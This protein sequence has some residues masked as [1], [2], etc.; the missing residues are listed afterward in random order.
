MAGGRPHR[1]ASTDTKQDKHRKNADILIPNGIR[2]H[3]PNIRA[4]EGIMRVSLSGH[5]DLIYYY[6]NYH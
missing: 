4:V 5:C 6:H 2:T 3:D 1:K